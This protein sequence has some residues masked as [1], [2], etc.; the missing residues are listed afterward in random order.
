MTSDETTTIL[1]KLSGAYFSQNRYLTSQ[2][3]GSRV[4]LWDVYFKDFPYEVVN[5]VVTDWIATRK[6]MPQ[7]SEL[8]PHCKDERTAMQNLKNPEDIKPTWEIIY[9]SRKGEPPESP[10]FSQITERFIK[11]LKADPKLRQIQ[12]AKEQADNMLPYEI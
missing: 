12:E 10:E 11:W 8:L 7:I 6:E 2:E 5:K 9:L 1:L 3:F 4:I